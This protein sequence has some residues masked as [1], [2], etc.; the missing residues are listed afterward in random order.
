MAMV[1]SDAAQLE[2]DLSSVAAPEDCGGKVEDAVFV[3]GRLLADPVLD[4]LPEVWKCLNQDGEFG[5]VLVGVSG[6]LDGVV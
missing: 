6:D 2:R 4:L 1:N 5:W 3:M